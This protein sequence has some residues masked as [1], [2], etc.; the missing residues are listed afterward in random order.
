MHLKYMLSFNNN[1][2]NRLGEKFGISRAGAF[3]SLLKD[4][5]KEKAIEK[6]KLIEELKASKLKET[7]TVSYGSIKVKI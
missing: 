4:V 1:I 6:A 3:F 2:Y 7:K 5:N